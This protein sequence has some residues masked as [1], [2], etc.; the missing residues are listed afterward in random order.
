MLLNQSLGMYHHLKL[1]SCEMI[2][3]GHLYLIS[4]GYF[5]SSSNNPF[6]QFPSHVH[7]AVYVKITN[8]KYEND[9]EENSIIEVGFTMNLK[10]SNHFLQMNLRN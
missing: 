9:K 10:L 6:T 2:N 3:P 7:V 4:I 8:V 5:Y 1:C